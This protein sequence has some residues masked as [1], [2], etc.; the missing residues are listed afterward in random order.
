MFVAALLVQ[1]GYLYERFRTSQANEFRVNL[2]MARAV[3]GTFNV[4]VRDVLHQE[5][6]IGINLTM[7]HGFSVEQMNRVLEA[8]RA[9]LPQI[10]NLAWVTPEGRVVASSMAPLVGEDVADRRYVLDIIKGSEWTVSD[11]LQSR[12]TGDPVFSISRGIRDGKGK[13]LGIVVAAVGAEKLG[14]ILGLDL[15]PSRNIAI[16]DGRAMLVDCYPKREMKW[17]DRDVLNKRPSI[18][19][20]MEGKEVTGT[21]RGFFDGEDRIVT[22]TPSRLTAWIVCVSRSRSE[23]MAHIRSQAIHL[24][25]FSLLLTAVIFIA[26]FFLSHGIVDPIRRLRDYALALGRGDPAQRIEFKGS[27]E[28][29]DLAS[30]FATMAE[31]INHRE[32]ALRRSEEKYRELVENANCII[33]RLSLDGRITFFNEFAQKFFGYSEEEILGRHIVGTIVPEA[34]SVGHDL[35]AVIN[36]VIRNPDLYAR[37]ENENMRRNGDRV[38]VMWA[39]KAL[40]DGE[41]KVCGVQG[42]G[43]DITARKRAEDGLRKSEQEKAGILGSLRKVAVHYLDPEMRVTWT[44]AMTEQVFG[45]TP[46]D[47]QGRKCFEAIHGASEPCPECTVVKAL[48]TGEAQQGEISRDGRAWLVSSN[49]IK[50]SSGKVINVVHT[51]MNITARKQMEEALRI[52]ISERKQAEAMR[53]L[54]EAR[55]EALWQ[56]SQMSES[57]THHIAQFA[58]EQLVRLT[59]SEVGWIGFLDQSET[60]L[61]VHGWPENARRGSAGEPT[62][63]LPVGGDDV[64]TKAIRE[65]RVV[66]MNDYSDSAPLCGG[67]PGTRL[68]VSRIMIVPVFENERIVAVAGAGNKATE[69]DPSDARQLTLLM[70]GMWKIIQRERAE[71]HLRE[72]ESLAA[73]GR[74]MAAVAHDMKTPLIAIGGFTRMAQRRIEDDNPVQ[75][76]LEIVVKETLRMENMVK[77]M[78]DFSRPLKL[79]LSKGD[80]A[81]LV[82]ECLTVVTPLAQEKNIKLTSLLDSG[83]HPEANLD[84]MRMKRVLINLLTNAI[85]ASQEGEDVMIGCHTNGNNLLI[86]V[87]DH[88]CGIPSDKRQEVFSPFYTSKKE[89][90]GLGLPIVKKIVEAHHGHIEIRENP[91]KGTTFRVE[92]PTDLSPHQS[93]YC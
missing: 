16:I 15:S 76:L 58:L 73:M 59:E 61:T 10:R 91:H 74:A 19:Q 3:A 93:L 55:L 17:E 47:M 82:A 14:S 44:N 20:A 88:G 68:P 65:K 18:R 81:L 41:G 77:S 26:A 2:D 54:D 6:A 8:N 42:I 62:L 80:I 45:L 70:D 28:L 90:T 85:Q 11:L 46:E 4:F 7:P 22:C 9:A 89:G 40:V 27:V 39:N 43:T 23:A 64:F 29:Q 36:D 50:D 38:W 78:L 75:E 53:R 12:G 48:A 72:S 87:I 25:G 30:S 56:L 84:F 66:V 34:D 5:L 57:S 67:F 31:E 49:P 51:A 69:Y 13:L 79:D 86:S 33:I 21:F 52:E 92:I 24:A 32:E 63:E 71:K 83:T 60:V 37:H 35:R 1:A